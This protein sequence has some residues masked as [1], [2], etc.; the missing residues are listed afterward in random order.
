MFTTLFVMAGCSHITDSEN[1]P[2]RIIG[3]WSDPD[4]IE[5]GGIA[6]WT[7][8]AEDDDGDELEYTWKASFGSL[9]GSGKSVIW[10]VPDSSGIYT[11]TCEV[12]DGNGGYNTITANV[13][14]DPFEIFGT[15]DVSDIEGSPISVD[16]SNS[17]WVF[18][19]QM[20]Y[21]WFL[22]LPN[23]DM[24]GEGHY[25]FAEDSSLELLEGT[26]VN[27]FGG[28]PPIKLIISN[29]NNTFSLLDLDGYRWTYNRR[30]E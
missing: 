12:E 22:L 28:Y 1:H 11:V 18:G 8:D 10:T 23:I 4:V 3:F 5:R 2:P 14:V 26:P 16:S 6:T 13:Y 7:C 21:E 30:I 15:W 20:D 17:V 25:H 27:V 9:S 29:D 24:Q 19:T